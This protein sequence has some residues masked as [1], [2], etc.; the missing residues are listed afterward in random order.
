MTELDI[1]KFYTALA[2]WLSCLLFVLILESRW[3][4]WVTALILA[5]YF[6][7][8]V[9]LQYGIGIWP[10]AFW[11]PAM[12]G[13]M[14]LIFLC[15]WTCCDIPMAETGFRFAVAFMVAEFMAAFEWQIAY[16][17][18]SET[19]VSR[20]GEYAML[21][22]I[23][24]VMFVILYAFGKKY[25]SYTPGI[26]HTWKEAASSIV[27][28][29]AVFLVSN[30]SYVYP[31]TPF[32]T[33]V[34][35]E[36]VYIRALVDFSGVLALFLLQSQWR[37]INLQKEMEATNMILHHQYEQYQMSKDSI[38]IINRKYHDLKHQIA[39]VRAE[40]N[41]EKREQ[42][43]Q[44]LEEGL[45]GY[46]AQNKTG[47]SVLDTILT[48]KNMYCMQRNIAFV[49]SVD[50]TILEFMNVMDLCTIFGNALD[51]AIECEEKLSDIEKRMVRVSV[52]A[53]G[54]FI[55]IRVENYWEEELETGDDLPAT[56]K[57]D[58]AYHGYGLKS[59]RSIAEKYG[60][61]MTMRQEEGW[62]QTRIMIPAPQKC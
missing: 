32:S 2:E 14:A 48:G 54:H 18:M 42:Y 27:M 55:I 36:I 47:N 31:H 58:T 20:V 39:T 40:D 29:L 9:L 51:N 8:F 60:G 62:V 22:G 5:A 46:G 45:K 16:F 37:E 52:S 15:I 25:F 49:T 41:S 19:E 50:G 3:K 11:I 57:R 35:R 34:P 12:V 53:Q 38:D 56:T 24:A 59:I 17:F 7:V 4:K 33:S 6:V 21:I 10:V 28:A 13:A 30:I 44:E 61:Y 23:Y 43:L 1:P 26:R